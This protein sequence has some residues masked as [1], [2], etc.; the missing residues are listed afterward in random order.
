[1]LIPAPLLDQGGFDVAGLSFQGSQTDF[2]AAGNILTRDGGFLLDLDGAGVHIYADTNA[3]RVSKTYDLDP[4]FDITAETETAS[5]SDNIGTEPQWADGGSKLVALDGQDLQVYPVSTPYDWSTLGTATTTS[6]G[7]VA[8]KFRISDNGARL[9]IL[10]GDV[11][12]NYTLTVPFD[13]R[14]LSLQNSINFAARG[15]TDPE[16]F[17]WNNDKSRLF[18]VERTLGEI[19]IYKLSTPGNLATATQVGAAVDF[20]T[21]SGMTLQPHNINFSR[22][23]KNMYIMDTDVNVFW[24]ETV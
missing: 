16:C 12:R 1:M 13:G 5:Y 14:T 20:A 9:D 19:A 11:L 21:P 6:T 23:G 8:E 15:M 18:G 17:T 10:V 4:A 22:D 2:V 7:L 3:G 24:F